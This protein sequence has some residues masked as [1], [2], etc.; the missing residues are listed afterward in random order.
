MGRAPGRPPCFSPSIPGPSTPSSTPL[1]SRLPERT[2]RRG[3]GI[4]GHHGGHGRG[5][6][7]ID[8]SG[9]GPPGMGAMGATMDNRDQVLGP[10]ALVDPKLTLREGEATV[11]P[12]AAIQTG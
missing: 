4:P 11:V 7:N 8:N 3:G 12:A 1:R 9:D 6:T 5:L 10:G 2:A